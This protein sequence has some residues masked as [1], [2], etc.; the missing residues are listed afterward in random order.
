MNHYCQ[1]KVDVQIP[2]LAFVDTQGMRLFV[3]AAHSGS[4]GFSLGLH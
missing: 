1:M 3:N 4:F 2:F